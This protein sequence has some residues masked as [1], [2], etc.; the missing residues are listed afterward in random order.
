MGVYAAT[1][2]IVVG[3]VISASGQMQAGKAAKA[4]AEYQAQVARN[5]AIAAEQN[6]DYAIKVGQQ[7]AAQESQK[8]AQQVARIKAAQAASGLNINTGSALDVQQSQREI[9]VLDAET[10]MHNAQLQAYGYR[11]QAQNFRSQADLAEFEGRSAAKSAQTGA[12]GTL[13]SGFGGAASAW[14]KGGGG[15]G[16]TPSTSDTLAFWG[17]F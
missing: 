2:A 7:K 14:Y 15:G 9:N 1:A 11:S 13:L 4:S 12:F 17:D 10:V 6:A 16:S 3:T 5:N 8:G